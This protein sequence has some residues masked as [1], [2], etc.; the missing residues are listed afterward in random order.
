[1]AYE[2]MKFE[3][4]DGIAVM[5]MNRP[6]SLNSINMQMQA[7]MKDIWGQIEA[8]KSIRVIIII[9][10]DKCFCAGAD[11]KEQ[12]P[13]GHLRPSSR[14]FFKKIEDYDVPSIA[15]ISGFCLG[16]ASNLPCAA[17]CAS[18]R[19]APNWVWWS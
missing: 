15:A 9:G 3:K 13:P 16:G 12:F 11:I 10:S 6:D 17:I 5:T 19:T 18:P 4:K 2:T 7:E 8:D 1:M 14:D